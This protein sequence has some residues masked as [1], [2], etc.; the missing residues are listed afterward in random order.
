MAARIVYP[1]CGDYVYSVTI[2]SVIIITLL[3][4]GM[5]ICLQRLL[6]VR[7][8]LTETLALACEIFFI[9]LFFLFFEIVGQAHVCLRRQIYT[10]FIIT[11]YREFLMQL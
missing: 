6:V 11:R 3:I 5:G 1:L 9:I 10:V 4:A 7:C 2:I 8:R